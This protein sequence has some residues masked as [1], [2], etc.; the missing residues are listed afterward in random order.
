MKIIF[1]VL[2][3][4]VSTLSHADTSELLTIEVKENTERSEDQILGAREI[5]RSSPTDMKTLFKKAQSLSVGGGTATGQKVYMRGVEDI[6][7]NIQVDGARQGGYL[8]HHQ[9]SLFVEPE[10]IKSVEVRPGTGR[11][12]DGYGALGGT[13]LLKTKNVFDFATDDHLHGGLAKTTYYS[14]QRYFRP[15]L[16]LFSQP[17]KN[18]GVLAMG[19]YKDGNSYSDGNGETIRGTSEEQQAGLIKVSGKGENFV[20]DLGYEHVKDQGLRAPRQN[21]GWDPDDDLLSRQE[22][23]RDTL[24]LNG[25]W[26]LNPDYLNLESNLFHTSSEIRREREDEGDSKAD[27]TGIGATIA[28]TIEHSVNRLKFGADYIINTSIA[29]NGEEKEINH[30]LFAQDRLR[31]VKN[32][33]LDFGARFDRHTFEAANGKDY[34]NNAFSPNGR[35]EYCLEGE[36][37]V[38]TGYSESFRGIR[39]AEA[40]LINGDIIYP[41]NLKPEK[42]ITR[43]A[44][45]SFRKDK[46]EARLVFYNTDLRDLIS[47][48]RGTHVRSNTGYLETNG[49]EATYAFNDPKLVNLRLGYT[50]IRPT[51]NGST[52]LNQNLGIGT[53]LGDTWSLSLSKLL[54]KEGILVGT[55]MK[56][57]ERID[58]ETIDKPSY[59]IY[60]I[61]VEYFPKRLPNWNFVVYMANIFDETYTDHG[62]FFATNGR[63]QLFSPG[64][65]IRVSATYNF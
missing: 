20:Y 52:I 31:M 9:G 46:H 15:T 24:T 34:S 54:E 8:F 61:W 11:A 27:A 56:F 44:G 19:T 3:L 18:F 30:G 40:L 25:A 59:N 37:C 60:D 14:N 35:I 45:T 63:D 38:F 39:P 49:Y 26:S 10:F 23:R 47:I 53:T 57:V 62:T 4:F 21:F 22:S 55:F 28:N 43:E 12:D 58:T 6:N 51:F 36:I 16:G 17:M 48:N 5:Q 65:D 32:L 13:L 2:V 41:D 64:R 50:Q 1:V 29:V 33:N 42:S 7:L